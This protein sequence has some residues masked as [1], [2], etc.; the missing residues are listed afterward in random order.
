MLLTRLL[1]AAIALPL[2]ALALLYLPNPAWSVFLAPWLATAAWEWAA[3]SGWRPA[4]RWLYCG[5]LVACYASA[6]AALQ[7]YAEAEP[8]LYG[9]SAA[10]WLLGASAWLHAGWR[11]RRALPLAVAGW[12]VLVPA[13]V[14]LSRLQMQPLLLLLLLGV[15]W[16]ADS[17]AYA[18]GRLWGRRRLAPAISPGKTWEGVAGAIA[19]VAVYYVA[20]AASFSQDYPIF[21]G[22]AGLGAF[23]LMTA[24]SIE[25]DLF[26]SWIKRLAGAKDSGRLL[27]GHG[28]VLDRIDGLTASMPAAALIVLLQH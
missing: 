21:N 28:G 4:A 25:G 12:L 7:V 23:V 22:L 27:P 26:E 2:F 1:T 16:I 11:P 10:F 8:L 18:A 14:A 9:V 13:A 6:L 20:L 3:L 24:M 5:L 17:A 19:A 15:V